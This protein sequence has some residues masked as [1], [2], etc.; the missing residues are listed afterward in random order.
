[1]LTI[2]EPRL[3]CRAAGGG[4]AWRRVAVAAG[5]GATRRRTAMLDP[6]F[7]HHWWL[8]RVSFRSRRIRLERAGAGDPNHWGESRPVP[9]RAAF[10]PESVS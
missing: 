1:M 3:S 9:G 8:T 6:G 7:D 10:Q 2:A 5:G 4:G